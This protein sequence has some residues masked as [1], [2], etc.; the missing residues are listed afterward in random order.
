MPS[1]RQANESQSPTFVFKGTVK[2]L[3]SATMKEVPLN[4][5]TV[6]VTVDQ[7]I[8]APPDLAGYAGQDITVKLS[9]RQKVSVGQQMVF[10]TT[11]WMFG[12]SVAVLSL[13][14]E[15]VKDV[16]AAP[17]VRG[18]GQQSSAHFEG[19]DLV[20]S[21]K[22]VSVSLP[23]GSATGSQRGSATGPGPITEHDPKWREA[24]IQVD[25]VL[26]GTHQKKQVVVRFPASND[27]MWHEV[28]KFKAGQQGYFILHHADP[29]KSPMR[30]AEKKKG[31][32][33]TTSGER[34]SSTTKSYM[35]LDSAD[36]QPY[37]EGGGIR[38][39][40]ESESRK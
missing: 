10:H 25:E 13:K 27:A 26:K 29:G 19:G 5:R 32:S 17:L 2:K 9:G 37:D 20:V 8:Q 23:G 39:S 38:S 28:P 4:N 33:R 21:G 16:D 15:P 3:N 1:P 34:G 12:D 24:V 35:V 22:V 31:K 7:I 18:R 40:L 36:F 30:G 11:V 6:V 14:Q